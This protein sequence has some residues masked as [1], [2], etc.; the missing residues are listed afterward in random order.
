MNAQPDPSTARTDE[1]AQVRS[2]PLFQSLNL[3]QAHEAHWDVVS[4]GEVML[5][6]DPGDRPISSAHTFEVWEGGGEYN[7]VRAASTVFGLKAGILT[8]LVDNEIGRLIERLMRA[9]GVDTTFVKWTPFDGIGKAARNPLNFT[10]RGFGVRSAVGVSDRAHSPA[11]QLEPEDFEWE[12]IFS[13]LGAR[14]FH[15]GGIFAGLSEQTAQV[16]MQAIAMA[17]DAGTV[18]SYDLNYRP[19]LWAQRGGKQAAQELNTKLAAMVDVLIG[20]EED[21]A[22]CLGIESEYIKDVDKTEDWRGFEEI[23]LEA[24]RRYPNIRAA[25]MTLRRVRSASRNDWSAIGAVE[26]QTYKGPTLQDMEIY[27]R[28]GGGDGFVSGFVS[29]ILTGRDFAQAIDQGIAHGALAMTTPGDV[30]LVSK[31]QVERLTRGASPRV[32]R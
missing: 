31:S 8:A 23:L 28:V 22:D 30:S 11:S 7:V 1:A 9:G 32:V 12:R 25:L 10:D 19:S 4:L 17:K 24:R 27:D 6:L 26:G 15:T 18:V 13:T 5:R 21:Y 14:W 2:D 29:G 20:N 3:R 16:A